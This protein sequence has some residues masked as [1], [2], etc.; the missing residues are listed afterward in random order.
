[1]PPLRRRALRRRTVMT[2]ARPIRR[3][4]RRESTGPGRTALA[5]LRL[6]DLTVGLEDDRLRCEHRAIVL[7]R[8]RE[9]VVDDLVFSDDA[10]VRVVRIAKTTRVVA[11]LL[12]DDRVDE[13]VVEEQLRRDRVAVRRRDG[14]VNVD[15]TAVVPAGKA[16]IEVHAALRVGLLDTTEPARRERLRVVHR[17][18]RLAVVARVH[19]RRTRM[20]DVDGGTRDRLTLL[21]E[22]EERET[23][24]KTRLTFADVPSLERPRVAGTDRRR[25]RELARRA[26]AARERIRVAA[27]HRGRAARRPGRGG[28]R[29]LR[30]TTTG[31]RQRKTP[32]AH[33]LQCR[34]ASENLHHLRALNLGGARVRTVGRR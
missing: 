30:S 9:E 18:H 16:G 1:M 20:P 7:A 32:V 26:G 17:A 25:A 31:V 21:V 15:R 27:L 14:E 22:D 3:A 28:D 2:T 10:V 23:D 34:A 19:P 8:R 29:R 33:R 24:R 11:R 13:G 12:R 5:A 6:A 4:A